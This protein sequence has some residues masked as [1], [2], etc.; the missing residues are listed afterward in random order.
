MK[1]I[2]LS[3]VAVAL[4]A[5]TGQALGARDDDKPTD[6]RRSTAIAERGQGGARG[7]AV[8]NR[9]STVKRSP[10][11]SR[12]MSPAP[13]LRNGVNTVRNPLA[14]SHPSGTRSPRVT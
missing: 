11:I 10:E 12:P 1:S 4:A 6:G 14:N 3:A 13:A 8:A 7:G 5:F 9:G 2:F